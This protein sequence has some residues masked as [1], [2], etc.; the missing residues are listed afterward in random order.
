MRQP[1]PTDWEEERDGYLLAFMCIP[2]SQTW[3][4]IIR[5]KIADLTGFNNWDKKTGYVLPV[6]ELA[7]GIFDSMGM[8]KLD[9]LVTEFKRL[10][11]ILAGEELTV[12][13]NGVTRHWDYTNSGL[14]PTL[15]D[16]APTGT[17]AKLEE[18]KSMLETRL[19]AETTAANTRSDLERQILASIA[20]QIADLDPYNDSNLVAKLESLKSML[21]TRLVAETTAANTRAQQLLAA[22]K[23][24]DAST[25]INLINSNGGDCQQ[26]CSGASCSESSWTVEEYPQLTDTTS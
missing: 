24:I 1:V 4:A 5:G 14:V 20:A 25:A 8:C 10:N 21:E 6:I 26:L 12:V 13:Q 2:N 23:D 11:A 18:L 19:V 16:L 15:E 9:D 3:R 7:Q 22:I 17:V